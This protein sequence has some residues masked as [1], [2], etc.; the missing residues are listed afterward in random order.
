MTF[1]IRAVRG[2]NS[3]WDNRVLRPLPAP[4][5]DPRNFFKVYGLDTELDLAPGAAK[6][7]LVEAMNGQVILY[8][9]TFV[10]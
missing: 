4:W 1:P 7:Q 5:E 9:E 2:T 8:W 3:F 10:T 6:D